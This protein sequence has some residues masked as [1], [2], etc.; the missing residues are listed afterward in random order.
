[1]KDAAAPGKLLQSCPT[2]CIPIDGSPPGSTVPESHWD[3]PGKNT[4][5]GCHFLFQ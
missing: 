2:L 1:M 5:V 4:G 3:S